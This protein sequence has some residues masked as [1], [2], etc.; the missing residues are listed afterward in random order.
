[1]GRIGW[2]ELEP[3]LA[4]SKEI[5]QSRGPLIEV[6]E[7]ERVVVVGDTHTAVDVTAYVFSAY[8]GK[9]DLIVFLG[10]YVDRGETGVENLYLILGKML[11]DPEKVIVLRGNH[12][13]PMTNYY[14]GFY[15]EVSGSYGEEKYQDF[16]DLFSSMPYAALVNDF[17][18]VHGGIARD[19]RS[20]EEIKSLP[21]HDRDPSNQ[22]ALEILWNDPRDMISGFVPSARGPGIFYFGYDV[23]QDFLERNGLRGIIRG[24]EVAD[25]FR[26]DMEGRV[27]TVFSSRYHRMRAGVLRIW[28][29]EIIKEWLP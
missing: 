29:K 18:M 23:T 3:Y 1:M 26:S 20:V 9:A 14:Y 24:H 17:L 27:I 15:D 6:G 16:V 10:D 21:L 12:E 28:K 8:W 5:F 7:K 13:S 4:K 25:G 19:L 22:V 11:Q 2:E